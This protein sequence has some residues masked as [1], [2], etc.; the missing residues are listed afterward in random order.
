MHNFTYVLSYYDKAT[1][2]ASFRSVEVIAETEMIAREGI[3]DS[4]RD[5]GWLM[6]MFDAD[7]PD[8]IDGIIVGDHLLIAHE[9]V[10]VPE[11]KSYDRGVATF[12]LR[13]VRT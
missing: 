5:Q 9:T 7:E 8:E 1:G 6:A 2:T 4:K 13:A 11:A 10:A 12:R 3:A